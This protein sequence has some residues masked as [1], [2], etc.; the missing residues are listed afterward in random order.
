MKT[1]MIVLTLLVFAQLTAAEPVDVNDVDA[2]AERLLDV[3]NIVAPAEYPLYLEVDAEAYSDAIYS[4]FVKSYMTI[5][6]E[7]VNRPSD[8]CVMLDIRHT[9]FV[10][11]EDEG[12]DRM[13]F[14]LELSENATGKILQIENV[15][16]DV[17]NAVDE[18]ESSAMSWYDPII[19]TT[20]VGGLIY[21]FYYGN[22]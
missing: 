1:F 12:A 22:Q 16:F 19:I 20:I 7:V 11:A 9:G 4:G 15:S 18:N 2:V 5:G 13:N 17:E 6:Y 3:Q 21:V 8:D 14:V 10:F